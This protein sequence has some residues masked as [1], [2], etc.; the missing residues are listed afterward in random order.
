MPTPDEERTHQPLAAFSTNART[1][2]RSEQRECS[3][4]CAKP[5]GTLAARLPC[6]TDWLRPRREGVRGCEPSG[7][8]F[9]A[10]VSVVGSGVSVLA[11][12][13]ALVLLRVS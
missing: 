3:T 8:E 7:C 6:E 9:S 1:A 4:T 5:S 11:G 13:R 10:S 2:A 12:W